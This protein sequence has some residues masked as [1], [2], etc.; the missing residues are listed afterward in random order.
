MQVGLSPIAD[1]GQ[2]IAEIRYNLRSAVE[3]QENEAQQLGLVLKEGA[4]SG[5][6]GL[7]PS[8]SHQLAM[9]QTQLKFAEV[10]LLREKLWTKISAGASEQSGGTWVGEEERLHLQIEQLCGKN[11][12][13]WPVP[14]EGARIDKDRRLRYAT[15]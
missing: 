2:A 15:M 5:E 8:D 14:S 1:P 10:K 12:A 3:N 6:K 13:G 9:V 7:N 11:N 4:C